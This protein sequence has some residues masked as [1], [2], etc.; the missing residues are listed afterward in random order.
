MEINGRMSID[1]QMPKILP[2]YINMKGED[3]AWNSFTQWA[4]LVSKILGSN[5]KQK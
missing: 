4:P 1:F 5:L 3:I 2:K